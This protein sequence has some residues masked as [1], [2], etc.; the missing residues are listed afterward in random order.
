MHY[1][2]TLA[3]AISAHARAIALSGGRRG[4][5]DPGRVEAAVNRP[6]TGYHRPIYKK[7]A[8]LIEAVVANHG[9]VDG[10]KR[11]ALLLC[12]LLLERSGFGLRKTSTVTNEDDLEHLIIDMTT[13]FLSVTEA[14]EWLKQRI[15]RA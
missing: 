6:Y 3:D 1:R 14:A 9:F 13:H 4:I 2:V 5:H 15:Y 10:N 8:P 7:A 11:T 12:Y